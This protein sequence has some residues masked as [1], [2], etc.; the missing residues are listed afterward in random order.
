MVA[1]AGRKLW[2]S[3]KLTRR[4]ATWAQ[5]SRMRRTAGPSPICTVRGGRT[6]RC[7][8]RGVCRGGRSSRSAWARGAIVFGAALIMIGGS[9]LGYGVTCTVE[10]GTT[11]EIDAEMA[12]AVTEL[13]G[14][15][16]VARA[17]VEQRAKTLAEVDR[18]RN[19][20]STDVATVLDM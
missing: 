7:G 11:P 8:R 2:T 17:A 10:G 13:D 9:A 20:V 1:F 19:A 6:V 14:T 3:A 12:K 15:I 4:G 18:V 16:K 5:T